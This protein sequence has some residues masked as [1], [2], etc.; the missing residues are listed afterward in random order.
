MRHTTKKLAVAV[1]TLVMVLGLAATA[2]AASAPRTLVFSDLS[3]NSAA[4]LNY[5][6]SI[7]IYEG[8]AGPGGPARPTDTLTRAEFC[9]VVVRMLDREDLAGALGTFQPDFVD[10][11]SIPSWAWGYVNV[12]YNMGIIEGY[13]EGT[14]QAGNPVT[15]AEA[16]AMLT[17]ALQN[18]DGVVGVWPMNYM[19]WAYESGLLGDLSLFANLPITR[20]EMAMLTVNAVGLERGYDPAAEE[21]FALGPIAASFTVNGA[22]VQAV[23]AAGSELTCTVG[24][25]TETYTMAADVTLSGAES[26]EALLNREVNLVFRAGEVVYIETIES[27][28]VVTGTYEGTETDEDGDYI[29]LEDGTEVLYTAKTLFE[30]NGKAEGKTVEDIAGATLTIVMDGEEAAYVK[31]FLEDVANVYIAAN[32]VTIEDEA[33]DEGIIGS[34]NGIDVSEDTVITLNGAAAG[35]ADLADYDIVYIATYG[36]EEAEAI[37]VTAIHDQVTGTVAEVTRSYTSEDEYD[38]VVT[39]EYKED[40]FR[41]ITLYEDIEDLEFSADQEYFFNLNREGVARYVGVVG[42]APDSDAIVKVVGFHSQEWATNR[43]TVDRAGTL[44]TYPTEDMSDA[45]IGKIGKLTINGDTGMV[46]FV[47]YG[48]LT[49]TYKVRAVNAAEGRL[50]FGD[51]AGNYWFIEDKTLAV[52]QWDADN[53]E[54]GDYIG[55]AGISVDDYVEIGVADTE[56]DGPTAA[57]WL[58]RIGDELP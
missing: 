18:E 13:P 55:L 51:E 46:S 1:L 47:E 50:T 48:R 38:T 5:L 45:D 49:G 35:L 28:A 37:K 33:T 26:F 12:A 30:V 6:G 20:G 19:M 27:G 44:A 31:A 3:G 11:A 53:G 24:A 52:Y 58:L 34:I 9:A 36:A 25:E 42:P 57:Q 4:A 32:G 21:E 56:G 22:L 10:G 7:G 41:D 15:A 16:L 54:V 39:V 17:R 14:F 40:H 2:F 29:V 8:D 43:V 23:D